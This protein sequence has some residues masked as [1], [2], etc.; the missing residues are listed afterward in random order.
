M[1]DAY[2]YT[3]VSHSKTVIGAQVLQKISSVYVLSATVKLRM[4]TVTLRMATVTLRMATVML[5]MATVMLRLRFVGY[6]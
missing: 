6:D 1:V 2:Y 4:A 3:K 5:R